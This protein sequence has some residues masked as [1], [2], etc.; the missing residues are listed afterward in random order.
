[1]AGD[2]RPARDAVK[3]YL[4]HGDL[5]AWVYRRMPPTLCHARLHYWIHRRDV[6]NPVS[7]ARWPVMVAGM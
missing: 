3:A 6:D 4:L 2:A 5:G 7:L 1:V